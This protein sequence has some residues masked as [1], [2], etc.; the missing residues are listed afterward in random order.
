MIT[1]SLW[2]RWWNKGIIM[3]CQ[4]NAHSSNKVMLC[5]STILSGRKASLRNSS[6]PP[7]ILV[8]K[9]NDLVY[10]IQLGPSTKCK[11]VHRSDYDLMAVTI[12][13][14]QPRDDSDILPAVMRKSGRQ[15]CM[16]T[17]L[18]RTAVDNL[19]RGE[20][21]ECDQYSPCSSLYMYIIMYVVHMWLSLRVTLVN[22]ATCC[23]STC[24]Y[25]LFQETSLT[26]PTI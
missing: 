10:T 9:I 21:D 12:Q 17:W 6:V 14:I 2:L 1:T 8:K 25:Y 18:I 19:R 7:Y 5:G 20:C 23:P 3:T 15:K 26:I 11:V 16:S 22:A 13:E 24:M 4:W